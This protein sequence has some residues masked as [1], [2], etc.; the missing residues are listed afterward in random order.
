MSSPD[1]SVLL[2]GLPPIHD[3]ANSKCATDT[4]SDL[5]SWLRKTSSKGALSTA[6]HAVDLEHRRAVFTFL[7]R[8]ADDPIRKKLASELLDKLCTD[9]AWCREGVLDGLELQS[10]S[11]SSGRAQSVSSSSGRAQSVSSSSGRAQSVISSSDRSMSSRVSAVA[12]V[13][14]PPPMSTPG[15]APAA[16]PVTG[17]TSKQRPPAAGRS[18]S[19]TGARMSEDPI[20]HRLARDL[21]G[22]LK[23]AWPISSRSGGG[24]RRSASTTRSGEQ[25]AA[26]AM[27]CSALMRADGGAPGGFDGCRQQVVQATAII[28]K[29]ITVGFFVPRACHHKVVGQGGNGIKMLQETYNVTVR[30]PRLEEQSCEALAVSGAPRAVEACRSAIERLLGLPV[31]TEPLHKM[32]LGVPPALYGALIGERGATVQALMAECRVLIEVPK[33][34]ASGNVTV[35]GR[36][37]DCVRAREKMEELFR[38]AVPVLSGSVGSDPRMPLPP[39]YDLASVEPLNR[40]LFF[41]DSPAPRVSDELTSLGVFLKYL[42]SSRVSCDVCVFTITDNRISRRLLDAHRYRGVT[43]RVI[44][45]RA[46]SKAVG[47]D[48]SDLQAA[49]IEVRMN[50]SEFHMHHK[51]CILDDRVVMNGSFNWTQGACENNSENVMI[52]NERSFLVGFREQFEAKWGEYSPL[53]AV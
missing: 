5:R 44:T 46:Q 33:A 42:D 35:Q 22:K 49:G 11:S 50:S 15:P 8:F 48:I 13:A 30:V 17:S 45:D 1:S 28:E 19:V 20:R 16:I 34:D 3:L 4:F 27:D 18:A 31:G 26:L 10:V 21:L 25:T 14:A 7:R 40:C 51:F 43:V 52:T 37:S 2:D 24:R 6:G 23:G 12:P 29:P 41:P 38:D 32:T 47:S 39:S 53:H 9:Q 36:S